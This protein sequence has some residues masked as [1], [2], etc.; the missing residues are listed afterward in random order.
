MQGGAIGEVTVSNDPSL[1]PGDLVQSMFGW[2]EA[3]NALAKDVQKLENDG[4]PAEAFLGIAGMPGLTAYV[5]LLHIASLKDGDVVFVSG[6]A[7]AVGSMVCQIA[8]LKG[9]KVIASAGGADKI[10]FVKN[11][12]GVDEKDYLLQSSLNRTYALTNAVRKAS[13]SISTMSVAIISTRRLLTQSHLAGLR[14]AA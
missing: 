13:M 7:G 1:R 12:L 5:G 14:C 11:E 4:L 10:A 2:R 9:H 8:K 6:A 3:F